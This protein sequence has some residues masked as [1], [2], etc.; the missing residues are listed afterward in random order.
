MMTMMIVMRSYN[1]M[2]DLY[3]VKTIAGNFYRLKLQ[4][5]SSFMVYY[6]QKIID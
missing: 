6:F 1:E 2:V 4:L 5:L 3:A